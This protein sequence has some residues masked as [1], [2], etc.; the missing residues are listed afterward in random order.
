MVSASKTS[1]QGMPDIALPFK[2]WP[3]HGSFVATPSAGGLPGMMPKDEEL[4]QYAEQ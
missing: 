1:F 3:L 2:M 4:P